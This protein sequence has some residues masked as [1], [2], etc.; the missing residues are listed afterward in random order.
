MVRR[1]EESS[2]QSPLS[3]VRTIGLCLTDTFSLPIPATRAFQNCTIANQDR[4]LADL[5]TAAVTSEGALRD[6]GDC[7]VSISTR[8]VSATTITSIHSPGHNSTRSCALSPWPCGRRGFPSRN[9]PRYHLECMLELQGQ[10]QTQSNDEG[11]LAS[12]YQDYS[13]PASSSQ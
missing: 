7:S 3:R 13:D 8:S 1:E 9:N 2:R 10:W 4:L 6:H 11:S 5:I 12:F